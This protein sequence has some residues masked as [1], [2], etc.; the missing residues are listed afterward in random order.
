MRVERREAEEEHAYKVQL[1]NESNTATHGDEQVSCIHDVVDNSS[2]EEPQ[3]N[4]PS[5]RMRASS[6][7]DC[8]FSFSQWRVQQ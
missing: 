5:Q 1:N 2:V 4:P 7:G 8:K 3:D 6:S